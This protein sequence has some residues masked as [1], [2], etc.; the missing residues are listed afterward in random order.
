MTGK[1]AVGEAGTAEGGIGAVAG[2]AGEGVRGGAGAGAGAGVEVAADLTTSTPAVPHVVRR[3]VDGERP[4]AV[5][6]RRGGV[7]RPW[8]EQRASTPTP[9]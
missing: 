3:R 4:A 8:P 6:R 7:E 5:W 2:A 1:K 9:R